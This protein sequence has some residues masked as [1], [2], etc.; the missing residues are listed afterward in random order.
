MIL[1]EPFVLPVTEEQA[2]AW[3]DDL[4]PKIEVVRRLATEF[5]A[6]LV[7]LDVELNKLAARTG[8]A[9]LAGDGV[10]PSDQGHAAISRLWLEVAQS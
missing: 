1:L 9:A 10:H 4:D 3:R 2:T 8:A 5:G 6:P 7:P